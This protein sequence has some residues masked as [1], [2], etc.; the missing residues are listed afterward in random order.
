MSWIRQ[1]VLSALPLLTVNVSSV[2]TL[3]I[4][5]QNVQP[6]KP[7]A[8]SATRRD[9]SRKCVAE[10]H[11]LPFLHQPTNRPTIASVTGP[12]ALSKA[13]WK[14]D[15]QGLEVG[16]L[17]DSGS[18]DSDCITTYPSENVISM[19]SASLSTKSLGVCTVNLTIKGRDYHNVRL[20]TYFP[21]S[22][23]PLSL[24]K[25]FSSSTIVSR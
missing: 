3:D 7:H 24:D 20:Y 10:N 6:V 8:T 16:G 12:S 14:I 23:W 4:P 22:V 15:I 19:A 21:N 18:T 13:I 17:I 1:I 2:V 11:F 9:I 5:V 25:T